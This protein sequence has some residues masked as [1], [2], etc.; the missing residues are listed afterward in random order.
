MLSQCADGQAELTFDDKDGACAVGT[1]GNRGMYS[2]V[3]FELKQRRAIRYLDL[4]RK[5]EP[6]NDAIKEHDARR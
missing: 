3:G 1:C 6:F 5:S 2:G 4:I